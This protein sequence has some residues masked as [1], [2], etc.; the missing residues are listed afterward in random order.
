MNKNIIFFIIASLV[1]F[2]DQLA[3]F[4]VRHKLPVGKE[5]PII[6]HVVSLTHIR[7]SGAAFGILQNG[8]I[9]FIIVGIV[10]LFVILY[11]LH[12]F[13]SSVFLIV[14]GGLLFGG[15]IGNLL[16]RIFLGY[17]T[18]F[19]YFAHWPVFNIADSCVDIG[20][21]LIAVYLLFYNNAPS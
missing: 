17:V 5:I 10:S 6:G 18:D 3:K 13:T 19:I 8:R 2:S 15:I 11:F 9:L 1:V 21:F 16:D 7:N 4:I 14:G 12:F 20:L